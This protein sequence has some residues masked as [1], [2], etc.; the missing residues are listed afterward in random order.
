MILLFFPFL[1]TTGALCL[2]I[3]SNG[4][5]WFG[6]PFRIDRG[7]RRKQPPLKALQRP[8]KDTYS[9]FLL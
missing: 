5:L 2:N 9:K 3:S 4:S 1:C 6:N 8:P 7:G